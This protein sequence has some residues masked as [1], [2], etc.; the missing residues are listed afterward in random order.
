MFFTVSRFLWERFLLSLGMK[1][2]K[3]TVSSLEKLRE[4]ESMKAVFLSVGSVDTKG[5]LHER[6]LNRSSGF[7]FSEWWGHFIY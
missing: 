3:T 4:E 1:L 2:L 5:G 7:C 6:K